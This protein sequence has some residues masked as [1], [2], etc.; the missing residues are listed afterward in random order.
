MRQP[1]FSQAI[2]QTRRE[3]GSSSVDLSAPSALQPFVAAALAA[4]TDAGGAG[5]P[6]LA[7]TAT[8][9]EAEQLAAAL[10]CLL[11]P[12]GIAVYPAWETLP[13]ERLS[14]RADTIGQRLSVL[15]RLVHPS[16]TDPA[17]GP[18][19]V[20]VAPVR[21]VL[22]PQ[23]VGLSEIEPVTVTAG[24]SVAIDALADRLVEL[25]Y[26]RVDLVSK[27]GEFALRGGIVDVFPP[28]EEHP[29]RVEFFGDEVE[30]IRYFGVA[31][32]RSLELAEH[33]LWAPPCRE[34]L[35]TSQ[36]RARAAELSSNHPELTE[37]LGKLAEGIA[38]E[39][40][41][42]LIPAL[43]SSPDELELVLAVLDKN[44]HILVCDPERVRSRSHDLVATS[45]EFRQASWSAAAVGGQ[46]PIDVGISAFRELE[47]VRKTASERGM[48]WWSI[49]PFAAEDGGTLALDAAPAP[50][51]RGDI[52]RALSQ[53]AQYAAA[54]WRVVLCFPGH[55]SAQRAAEQLRDADIGAA[56]VESLEAAPEPGVVTITTGEI[57]HGFCCE[58]L[59]L[60]LFTE[61]DLT[62]TRSAEAPRR[63][64]PKRRNTID[65]LQLTPLSTGSGA[66]WSC[67]AVASP[68]PNANTWCWSTR[69]V[70]GD[71]LVTGCSSPPTSWICS[72]A[73]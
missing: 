66:T 8:A 71:S 51:Y 11:P 36:V 56:L 50:S 32:Q 45:E 33:G 61:A 39:G 43:V 7:V 24:N 52:E 62:G 27:R 70:N 21:S 31:D 60:A 13:H 30:E 12:H 65:P 41:E 9:R 59:R 42:S 5:V 6:V 73:T 67:F 72:P 15:R 18:I 63:M 29:L 25:A 44:T 46:T 47:H 23:L 53:L 16:A 35:L 1:A 20:L 58:P 19:S 38:V 17:N 3:A 37:L 48:P 34:L 2:S 4:P 40:M 26:T 55:G 14:P 10:R 49:G 22:Q 54:G 68:A 57:E 28:T 64:A 69:R